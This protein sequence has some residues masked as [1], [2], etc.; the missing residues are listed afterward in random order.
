MGDTTSCGLSLLCYGVPAGQVNVFND[1]NQPNHTEF[2]DV[3]FYA[4]S[5]GIPLGEAAAMGLG[6]IQA[7]VGWFEPRE[8]LVPEL[9]EFSRYATT[10]MGRLTN[11]NHE[12][13]AAARANKKE[14]DREVT[15]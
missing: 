10:E 6:S 3:V 1:S 13:R 12:R 4:R 7:N 5:R 8:D 9:E 2:N 14:S 15:R 11:T